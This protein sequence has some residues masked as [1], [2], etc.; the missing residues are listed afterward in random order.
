MKRNLR[1]L[2]AAFLSGGI[3]ALLA[4]P[5]LWREPKAAPA[6]GPVYG[7]ADC[8]CP[9][10][11]LT[12]DDGPKRSTTSRLLDGLAERGVKATFFLIGCQ[13]DGCEDLVLRMDAEGH[14][15]GMHTEDHKMLAGVSRA[16]FDQEVGRNRAV[17]EKVLGKTQFMLRPPYGMTD[18]HL[19]AWSRYPLIRWSVD[20]EDWKDNSR[21]R[22]VQ[23]ILSRTK[24][25]DIIL[26]HSN[27]DKKATLEALPAIIEGLEKK[28]YKIVTLDELLNIT[29]YQ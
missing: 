15:I 23:E 27:G 7:T 16:T 10:I 22:I 25:G 14:Q 19:C 20:P 21:Q 1:R 5:V 2:G 8:T 29:P 3:L 6:L 13:V 26:M 17:L 28:G 18:G 4:V 9:V 12:F 24:D 11:A